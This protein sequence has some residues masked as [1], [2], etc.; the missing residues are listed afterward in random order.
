ML[1]L[2][3]FFPACMLGAWSIEL[4]VVTQSHVSS[5]LNFVYAPILRAC[6]HSPEFKNGL[7]RIGAMGDPLMPSRFRR[8]TPAPN[9]ENRDSNAVTPLVRQ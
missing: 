2:L 7:R 9:R 8:S 4:G 1:Y 6:D 3:S 5:T